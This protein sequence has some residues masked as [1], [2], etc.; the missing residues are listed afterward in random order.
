MPLASRTGLDAL[1]QRLVL[2]T[3]VSY[4]EWVASMASGQ[5]VAGMLVRADSTSP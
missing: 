1:D 4:P 2:E 5:L 3:G